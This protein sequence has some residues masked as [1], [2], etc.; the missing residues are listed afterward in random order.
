M[1][2]RDP[3][4]DVARTDDISSLSP[5]FKNGRNGGSNETKRISFAEKSKAE[6]SG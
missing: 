2:S 6:G 5:T 3:S 1:P 4:N